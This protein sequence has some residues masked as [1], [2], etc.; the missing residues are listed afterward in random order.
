LNQGINSCPTQ[1]DAP[2]NSLQMQAK[3]AML[4]RCA[5][6]RT[7]LPQLLVGGSGPE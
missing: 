2:G 7:T 5:I 6:V 3:A 4:D 1:N